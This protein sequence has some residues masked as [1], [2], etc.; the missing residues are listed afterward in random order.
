MTSQGSPA[1]VSPASRCRTV[2]DLPAPVAPVTSACLLR[3]GSGS[4]NSPGRPVLRVEDRP[5][6]DRRAGSLG[7]GAGRSPR[8][9]RPCIARPGHS[10]RPDRP[11]FARPGLAGPGLAGHVELA[12]TEYPQPGYLP[13]GQPG[14]C[15]QHARGGQERH[16][17]ARRPDPRPSPPGRWRMTAAP[18]PC[19]AGRDGGPG[20]PTR[21][22]R[23]PAGQAHRGRGP[24]EHPHRPQARLTK[25]VQLRKPAFRLV[26]TGPEPFLVVLA[27]HRHLGAQPGLLGVEQPGGL[28]HHEPAEG[29]APGRG[30]RGLEPAR[31]PG[32]LA[33]RGRGLARAAA[34]PGVPGR[35][36]R[37]APRKR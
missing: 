13:P 16:P 34:A 4:R 18:G 6:A 10:P 14:E 15:G 5:E 17:G 31:L 1:L 7:R 25:R 23:V 30:Q 2:C 22:A 24:D 12:D 37:A 35:V 21:R 11:C 8:P 36:P 32:L 20:R 28:G 26:S 29:P 9:D 19:R 33:G 3:V 27:Q